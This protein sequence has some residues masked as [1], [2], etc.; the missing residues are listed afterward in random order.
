MS[1]TMPSASRFSRRKVSSTT[2]VAPCRRWAWPKTSPRKLC[3]TMMWSRT[4]TLNTALRPVVR[5][6][7][8]ERREAS[9]SQ[10]LHHAG[11]LVEARF[12]RDERVERGVAQQLEREGQPV[13]GRA[14]RAPGRGHRADLARAQ[15][16]ATGVERAAQRE[17]HLAV[18]VP[19]QVEH[20]ALGCEQ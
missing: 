2:N 20:R 10:A 5:D 16:Q 13:G 17:A 14:A 19:A 6:R 8:A 3:A 15:P 11:Q 12:A 4:E 1:K 18:A 9:G 7:V